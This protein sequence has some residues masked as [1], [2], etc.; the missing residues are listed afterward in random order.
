[1]LWGEDSH[2]GLETEF[3][4]YCYQA[5]FIRDWT[6]GPGIP[7]SFGIEDRYVTPARFRPMAERDIDIIF[8]GTPF[9]HRADYLERLKRDFA[10]KSLMLSGRLF[11]EPDGSWPQVSGW[12]VHDPRYFDALSRSKIAISFHGAGPDCARHWEVLASGAVPMIE[13]FPCVDPQPDCFRFTNYNE[14]AEAIELCLA[15]PAWPNELTNRAIRYHSTTARAEYL[16]E[17]LGMI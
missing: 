13:E 3:K 1:M 10:G 5:F 15:N 14:L 9:Q 12:C 16:L 11:N 7:I 4:A 6:G 8:L 2:N 17:Q